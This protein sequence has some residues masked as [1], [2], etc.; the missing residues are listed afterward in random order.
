M[1]PGTPRDRA[2]AHLDPGVHRV[3]RRRARP[4]RPGAP[5]ARAR[6]NGS[7]RRQSRAGDVYPGRRAI[8]CAHAHAVVVAESVAD[9]QPFPVGEPVPES[10]SDVAS[11]D[12]GPGYHSGVKSGLARD[13]ARAQLPAVDPGPRFELTAGGAFSG[14]NHRP[15]RA[16]GASDGQAGTVMLGRVIRRRA[17]PPE[18]AV[19]RAVSAAGMARLATLDRRLTAPARAIAMIRRTRGTRAAS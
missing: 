15:A 9:G 8:A 19:S 6:R 17:G 1:R 18:S 13:V 3:V 7:A 11:P 4:L 12:A 10:N 5:G 14:G 16:G 2:A